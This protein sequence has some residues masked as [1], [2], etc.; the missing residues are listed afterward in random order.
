MR[1]T[2]LHALTA[3]ALASAVAVPVATVA[4]AEPA[5]APAPPPPRPPPR[6]RRC[7]AR[8]A[9]TSSASAT[10]GAPS[11]SSIAAEE[12]RAA[13]RKAAARRA[14]AK[15]LAAKKAAAAPE[16]RRTTGRAAA[17][18]AAAQEAAE[19]RAE[20]RAAERRASAPA[21]ASRGGSRTAL[22]ATGGSPRTV[23]R[24][25]LAARGQADQFGCLDNL[26]GKESGWSVS[27]D[28]PSSSA[29]G[30]PQALPG[31]KMASAGADWRTSARTQITWGLG[32][33]D[34]RYG[35]PCAAWSHSQA[36]NWY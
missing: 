5:V 24:S 13:E 30:I 31:S 26:W 4:L 10:S 33:I 12:Q 14:A 3:T 9:P 34:S 21:R 17:Q 20:A 16:G 25:M 15:A 19:R 6:S 23:A 2:F 32:Y 7:P 11:P 28:N 18:E 35:S 36:N 29:Y 1:R 27:A 22:P 8:S